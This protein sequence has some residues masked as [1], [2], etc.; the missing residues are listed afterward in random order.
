M[1]ATFIWREAA[2]DLALPDALP[3]LD[4]KAAWHLERGQP[5]IL[6]CETGRRSSDER[7]HCLARLR[8]GAQP[9]FLLAGRGFQGVGAA[10]LMPNSLSILGATFRGEAKGRA[11]GI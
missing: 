1:T 8:V 4:D 11:I 6:V 3:G 5:A 9:V 10:M 7:R 2:V